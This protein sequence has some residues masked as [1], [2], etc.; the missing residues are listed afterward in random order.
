MSIC[1]S[2]AFRD[3]GDLSAWTTEELAAAYASS[4]TPG[5]STPA[6]RAE[7][8]RLQAEWARRSPAERRAA[9]RSLLMRHRSRQL[10][11]DGHGT[12]RSPGKGP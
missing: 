11:P 3:P 4:L 1:M 7:R 9:L 6:E 2:M 5:P 10:R 12:G 8:V